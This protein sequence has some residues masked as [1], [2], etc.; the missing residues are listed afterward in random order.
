[1][2]WLYGTAVED[3]SCLA[4][5]PLLK[6]LNLRKTKVTNLSSFRGREDILGIAPYGNGLDFLDWMRDFLDGKVI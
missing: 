2:V 6:E 5:L 3:V 1:M 4:G